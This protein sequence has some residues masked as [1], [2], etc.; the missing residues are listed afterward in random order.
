MPCCVGFCC[1]G[2][3]YSAECCEFDYMSCC[4]GLCYLGGEEQLMMDGDLKP[5]TMHMQRDP[6]AV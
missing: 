3:F 4:V 5:L 1:F 6:M 2:E